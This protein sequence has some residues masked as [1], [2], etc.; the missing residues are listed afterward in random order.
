MAGPTPMR[1]GR[2]WAP[3]LLALAT[4]ALAE[5]PDLAPPLD[6][7]QTRCYVQRFV[8]RDPGPGAV[9]FACGQITTDGHKG[10]DIAMP[11]VDATGPG[12]PVLAAAA[13]RVRGIRDDMPDIDVTTPG[14]PDVTGRECGNGVVI[15]HENGWETQYCHLRRGS[16]GVRKGEIVETG[17]RLGLVGLSGESNFHHLHFSLRR[18]G[19]VIDPYQPEAE[20]CLADSEQGVAPW[21]GAPVHRSGGLV[22]VGLLDRL[23]DYS[24]IKAGLPS[25]SLPDRAPAAL[26]LWGLVF[27]G[28]TGDRISFELAYP[29]GTRR[30]EDVELD[31]SQ[32]QLFRAWGVK[33]PEGGFSAGE[34]VGSIRHLRG[35]EVLDTREI[36][37]QLR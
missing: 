18:G 11:P 10:T 9:D 5:I 24:E 8:D 27:E 15:A 28:R 20:N 36:R 17:Q 21:P 19:K 35:G 7:S 23:P 31:R 33:A 25:L 30:M 32:P 2:L 4:P 37:A 14:A 6:C 26:V 3:F 13:G 16:I 29:D 22:Q 1:K 34:Y 12:I